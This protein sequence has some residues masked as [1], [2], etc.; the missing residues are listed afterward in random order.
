M[1][2]V[3][4][5]V[6]CSVFCNVLSSQENIISTGK[7]VSSQLG[8]VN[9]SIGQVFTKT[10]T[11]GGI[12]I[13][14]GVQNMFDNSILSS[15]DVELV[16]LE[17]LVYPNPSSD[18]VVLSLETKDFNSLSF[19]IYDVQGKLL[20]ANSVLMNKT[21]IDISNLSVGAYFLKVNYGGLTIKSF[22]L[23]KY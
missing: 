19:S 2:N 21:N 17:M 3:I 12:T 1:K 22:Q 6:L 16:T 13:Y 15:L 9:Y 7:L 18:F 14:E 23:I 4:I 11:S 20:I 5:F 8:S 10:N